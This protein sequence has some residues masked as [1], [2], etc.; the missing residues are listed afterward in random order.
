MKH[1]EKLK[2]KK[3]KMKKKII[4]WVF[5]EH[6]IQTGMVYSQKMLENKQ[7]KVHVILL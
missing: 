6:G 2:M 5:R 7:K 1:L 4:C 3:I